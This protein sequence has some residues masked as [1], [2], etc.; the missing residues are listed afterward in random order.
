MSEAEFMLTLFKMKYCDVQKDDQKVLAVKMVDVY[1]TGN[2]WMK[3]RPFQE[4][5]FTSTGK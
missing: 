5:S 4:L 2:C 3:G 1:F